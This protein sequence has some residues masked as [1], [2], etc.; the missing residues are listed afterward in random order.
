MTMLLPGY[1]E[2]AESMRRAFDRGFAQPR[3]TASRVTEDLLAIRVAGDPY[4]ILLSD[5]AGLHADKRVSPV[6]TS[7]RAL[8][9]IAGFRGAIVPVYDLRLLLGYPSGPAPRWIVVAAS[10]PVAF[11]FDGLDGHRRLAREAITDDAPDDAPSAYLRGVARDVETRSI[12]H[13]AALL[14]A[15]EQPTSEPKPTGEGSA[16]SNTNQP[17]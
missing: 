15:I 5:V 11:A 6:P 3:E 14:A 16:V 12:V 8:L 1:T 9:G 13:L 10:K 2:R 7:A 17:R 4:A